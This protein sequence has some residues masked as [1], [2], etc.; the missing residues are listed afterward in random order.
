MSNLTKRETIEIMIVVV[1]FFIAIPVLFLL[2]PVKQEG[3]WVDCS[4][5]EF[6]PDY[7]PKVKEECRKLRSK[8][9]TTT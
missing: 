5:A 4:M 8:H 7:P 1:A 3:V 6:H 9:L 2:L